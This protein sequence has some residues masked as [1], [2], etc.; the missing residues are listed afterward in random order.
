MITIFHNP[1]CTKSRE[2]LQILEK[3]GKDF[4]V[5]KYLEE[6]ISEAQLK[7]IIAL[8]GIQPI[9]LVR[10]NEAIWKSD[11]K[12]KELNDKDVISAM[13]KNPKLIERPIVINNNKAVIGRPPSL[14]LD[15]I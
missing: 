2:G 4:E 3:S 7:K 5:V 13:I 14:I 15:I 8:L 11:F 10:K 9:D 1:R 6:S 12:G